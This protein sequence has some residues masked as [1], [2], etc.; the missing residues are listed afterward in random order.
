MRVTYSDSA[1]HKSHTHWGFLPKVRPR[2]GLQK[3]ADW[4]ASRAEKRDAVCKWGAVRVGG[5]GLEMAANLY[6]S[7]WSEIGRPGG[8]FVYFANFSS[9]SQPN[10]LLLITVHNISTGVSDLLLNMGT[11]CAWAQL[12]P[13]LGTAFAS[14][15]QTPRVRI[16]RPPPV[17]PPFLGSSFNMHLQQFCHLPAGSRAALKIRY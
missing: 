3:W 9:K 12:S 17:P 11:V 1:V 13:W 8:G 10:Y 2:S 5:Q 14:C 6:K 15:S 4:E 16:Y 7:Q